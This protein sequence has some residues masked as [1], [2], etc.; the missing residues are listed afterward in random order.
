MIHFPSSP[1]LGQRYVGVN[2]VTYTWL[3]DRW[4][5]AN[6]LQTGHA[7]YYVDNGDAGFSY[8]SI[9]DGVLDGLSADPTLPVISIIDY[10]LTSIPSG[11]IEF[12]VNANNTNIVE[13][14]IIAVVQGMSH[15]YADTTLYSDDN[16]TDQ[17]RYI[18]ETGSFLSG[19]FT[20][21]F[22]NYHFA[23]YG[24]IVTVVVYAKTDGNK[25]A[26]SD[27]LYWHPL[28]ICLVGGTEISMADGTTK[29]I[30]DITYADTLSVWNFDL[31][32]S[33]EAVPLWI[34]KP[35][36]ADAYNLAT[37]SD[38][39]ELRSLQAVKGHRVFNKTAGE[40]T[41]VGLT[42]PGSVI[43]KAD[44]TEVTLVS[45]EVVHEP[46]A[47]Y[48]IFTQYHMNM[49]ANGI[50]T[51]TGFNNLYPIVDMK[52][53]KDNRELRNIEGI[54]A[55]WVDGLRLRE[56]TSSVAEMAA[57]LAKLERLDIQATETV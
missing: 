46:V 22:N 2:G 23:D 28:V 37:F 39:T 30:E 43:V 5:A 3:G 1:S 9:R 29:V 18:S 34:K 55:R 56:N 15:Q 42:E 17:A 44:G 45:T 57:H 13:I 33:A 27:P 31:G 48:N 54:D 36:Y 47:F 53:V 41:F 52:F 40:F 38:G 35:Q 25:V 8:N 26:Y 7:E 51:S 20:E 12:S 4:S 49:Y 21:T 50:L 24:D 14:G 19:T 10:A 6:A 32:E 11:L 16:N